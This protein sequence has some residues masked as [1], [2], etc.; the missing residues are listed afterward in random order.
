[1]KTESQWLM[2]KIPTAYL[3]SILVKNMQRML[4]FNWLIVSQA[5][6]KKISF[7]TLGNIKH[8]GTKWRWLSWKLESLLDTWNTTVGLNPTSIYSGTTRPLIRLQCK[9]YIQSQLW[10]IMVYFGLP[11]RLKVCD[12]SYQGT[13]EFLSVICPQKYRARQVLTNQEIHGNN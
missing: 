13:E 3:R 9:S 1:M 2:W 12:R 5:I 6:F 7:I 11:T 4:N 10:L 8:K